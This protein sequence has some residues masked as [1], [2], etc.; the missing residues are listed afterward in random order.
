[1]EP[2]TDEMRLDELAAAAGVATTTVRLYQQRG[3]LPG[4]RIVGRTGWY[5][6]DHLE[7][8]RL[9]GRLQAQG[10]SLAGIGRLLE[11]AE[12]GGDLTDIVGAR[13]ELDTVLAM[14]EPVVVEPVE[15]IERFGAASLGPAEMARAV[16]LGLVEGTSDG[17]LRIPDRRFLEIGSELVALGVP[18]SKVLDEWEHLSRTAD[19]VARRF[20]QVFES[21]VLGDDWRDRVD[22]ELAA[23]TAETLPRLVQLAHQVL[24][25]ALDAAIARQVDR[26]LGDLGAHT[27]APT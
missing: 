26:N 5:S 20:V 19:D 25:A 24:D 1:M 22:P 12:R 23:R 2:T 10:F 27:D 7:R 9:I 6:P 18:A 13:Q 21:D 15:L 4:P 3:L 16:E 11:A 17:R 8:L 14:P